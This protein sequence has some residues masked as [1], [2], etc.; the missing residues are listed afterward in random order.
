MADPFA[1][2]SSISSS[3]INRGT[4]QTEEAYASSTTAAAELS[5]APLLPRRTIFHLFFEEESL[6][7]Y[8]RRPRTG[9]LA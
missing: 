9:V 7:F 5:L 3:V 2:T 4:A 6:S 1:H 8:S